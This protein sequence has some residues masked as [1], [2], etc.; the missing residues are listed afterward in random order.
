MAESHSRYDAG[1]VE[2]AAPAVL[3][4]WQATG[5]AVVSYMYDANG[6]VTNRGSDTFAWDYE[7]L[8]TSTTIGGTTTSFTY[9]GDGLRASQTSGSTTTSYTWDLNSSLPVVLDDGSQYVYGNGLVSQVSGASTYYY[10]ADG[11]GSTM[12]TTDAF[13]NVV[14]GYTYDVYGKT[15]ASSGSQP[16][17][18]EF[19]GQ[20]TDATGLQYLRARYYDP[21]TG[22]FL[23]RDPL[24]ALPSWSGS[25]FG[26]AGGNPATVRDP[27]GLCI[28]NNDPSECFFGEGEAGVG[29]GGNAE[30]VHVGNPTPEIPQ[31]EPEQGATT[32]TR[33]LSGEYPEWPTDP[34]QIQ[35]IF[36][37]KPGHVN[38]Q[39]AADRDAWIRT[40]KEV[41][42][43]P[44]NLR[45]DLAK[46][47]GVDV[48]VYTQTVE[49][50]AQVWVEVANGRISDAGLN[51]PGMAR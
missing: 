47:F 27:R 8:L 33:S 30:N 34:G 1:V 32:G 20:Q 7:N 17:S 6:N 4:R 36:D 29:P 10:L 16:N 9:R 37:D 35:H 44:A 39:S 13:G 43:D 5:T 25:P 45:E 48:T 46:H 28:D 15:T 11:L 2:L 38:P 50:G 21:A 41:A 26:Y 51:T 12:A 40:F 31:A 18:I 24:S 14:N 3:H 23:S 42:S 22:S 19:A 49:D